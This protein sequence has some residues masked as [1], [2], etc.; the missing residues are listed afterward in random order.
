VARPAELTGKQE[1]LAAPRLPPA[2]A[3]RPEL[4]DLAAIPKHDASPA[5]RADSATA[6]VRAS[7]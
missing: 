5:W 6:A 2:L 1:D 4:P 3:D 7:G